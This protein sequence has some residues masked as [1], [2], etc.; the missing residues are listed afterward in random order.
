LWD[1]SG[2]DAFDAIRLSHFK[3]SR[4]AIFV[5]DASSLASLE[6]TLELVVQMKRSLPIDVV[7]KFPILLVGN[8]ISDRSRKSQNKSKV[9]GTGK[10]V[11]SEMELAERVSRLNIHF[12]VS[13]G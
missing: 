13:F 10:W 9:T 6:S 1:I 12:S 11:C 8:T 5:F 4:G 3:R 7:A 2:S